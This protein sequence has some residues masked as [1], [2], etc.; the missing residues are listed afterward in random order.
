MLFLTQTQLRGYRSLR[1][2]V[3]AAFVA[4]ALGFTVKDAPSETERAALHGTPFIRSYPLEEIGNVPRG[5]TLSFDRFGRL[6]VVYDGFYSVLNDT[7]WLEMTVP[8]SGDGGVSMPVIVSGDGGHAYYGSFGSW[9]T[10]EQTAGG[11]PHPHPLVPPDPPRWVLETGFNDV[12]VASGGVFFAGWNGLVYWDLANQ[13]NQFFELFGYSKVFSLGDK[14][15]VSAYGSPLQRVDFAGKALQPVEGTNFG[16]DPIAQATSLDPSRA[17]VSTRSGRMFVFDGTRLTPWPGQLRNGLTGRVTSLQH[18][19]EGGVAIAIAGKGLYLIADDGEMIS[20]LTSSEFHRIRQLASREPRVLWAAG[21]DAVLKVLYGNALTVF[22]QR[23][24]L[25]PSWPLVARWNDKIVVASSGLLFEAV[26]A[27]S[28]SPSRFEPMKNLPAAGAWAIASNGPHLLVGNGKG[29]FAAESDGSFTTVIPEM[30]VA[31]L[32]MIG[33]DVCV[34]IGR[35]EI[36][37]IRLSDGRWTEC[38]P[39]IPS[40]GYPSVA[41]S[42]KRSVW[43]ELGANRVARL[44]LQ[45]GRMRSQVFESFPWKDSRW[46][47]VGI[48]DDTVVLSGPPG[49]RI[50]FD[51]NTEAFCAA[52]ELQRLLD[53]SPNWI[54]RVQ[55]DE[56]GTLWA[57]HEQGVITF[58]PKDGAYRIDTTTF[59]LN[60]EHFPIVQLLPGNDVWLSTGQSLYHVDN[61]RAFGAGG[62]PRASRRPPPVEPI[63]VSVTNGRTNEELFSDAT[64]AALP[65]RLAYSSND[66]SFRFFSGGYAWRRAP[67]YESK[68]SSGQNEWTSASTDSLLSFPGLHEGTY[69]LTVRIANARGATSPFASFQF[70]ILPP[71]PRT[72]PAYTF[73]AL[74]GAFSVFGFTRWSVRITR[75]RNVALEGI[76]RERT[77]QLKVTMQKLNDETRNAATLAE[78]DRL[79][80]EIHD[81]VQQ[82]LSGLMLQLDATMKLPMVTGELRSRLNVARNMVSFTRH[83]VQHA[84]WDME[85]PLLEGTELD[86]ALQKITT[87]IGSGASSIEISVSGSA[88]PL[89]SAIQHNLLRIAQEAITNAVRHAGATT[90]EVRLEYRPR[91]VFLSVTD[92]GVGFEPNEF[93]GNGVGHFGLRGLRGRAANISGEL[94]IESSPGRGTSIEVIVP[95][96]ET[97]MP[98]GDAATN[99]A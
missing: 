49:G 99:P 69:N 97:L 24:G 52:P 91:A 5:A 77:D 94:R 55:R 71:W 34:A 61:I 79:A 9:G 81:S 58:V 33:T 40:V 10:V 15:Y 64:S 84:I 85:S 39:R 14:V 37:A 62:T 6:A 83:E 18:L 48:V 38:V 78:R 90:I 25:N 47:N 86:E 51:E 96:S 22:G 35:V 74:A 46:V 87:L 12:L 98:S 95:L 1:W 67:V 60:N 42:A 53:E 76:V 93:L 4:P 19:L 3:A 23:L 30:D 56:T 63:L 32:A 88:V 72:W 45:G 20:A 28:G 2:G 89:P 73:Y 16:E 21:E 27:S 50:F 70:E 57:T 68:L 8:S 13:R 92:K 26:P 31:R 75:D 43:I 66:L 54:L 44:S 17:L 80:G 36:A 59:D 7:T 82:G 29:V 11:K 41:H 65:L